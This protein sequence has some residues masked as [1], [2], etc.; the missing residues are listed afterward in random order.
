MTFQPTAWSGNIPL[1]MEWQTHSSTLAWKIPMD[2]GDWQVTVH[3]V[4]NSWTRLSDFTSLLHFIMWDQL[5]GSVSK[6]GCD[7]RGRLQF[8]PQQSHL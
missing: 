8:E 4:A 7:G 5:R 2:G 3:G 6:S 1:E